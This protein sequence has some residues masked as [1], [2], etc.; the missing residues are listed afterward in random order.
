VTKFYTYAHYTADTNELFYIGKGTRTRFKQV[1]NRNK[2]WHNKVSK[3]GFVSK[4]LAWWD[5]ES[6]ALDHEKVLIDCMEDMGVVLVNIQKARGKESGGWKQSIEQRKEK[7]RSTK[8]RWESLTEEQ[9]KETSV[10][11]SNFLKGLPKTEEHKQNLSKARLGLKVPK[12]WKPVKCLT[13]GVVYDSVTEASVKT[14]CDA[15][16]IVKCCKGKLKKIK[17]L[18]FAYV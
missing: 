12:I 2:W 13:T 17:N 3:H 10:R 4:I 6:E 15:S 9:K 14:K 5:T 16:H 1:C 7:S 8:A 11:F 18:E